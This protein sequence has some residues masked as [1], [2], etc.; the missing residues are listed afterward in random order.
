MADGAPQGPA[1]SWTGRHT[2]AL[3]VL[4]LAIAFMGWLAP[5]F[6]G[7]STGRLAGWILTLV[8]MTVFTMV[9]G[10]GITGL[11]RGVLLDD[12][13]MLSLSRLQLVLWTVVVLSGLLTMALSNVTLG[14]TSPLAIAIPP[15]LWLVMGI[16]TTSLVGSP[17]VLSTKA[18]PDLTPNAGELA[19]TSA[20]LA[21]QGGGT[22]ITTKG[23]VVIKADP[24]SAQWADLFKGEES[25]N[26]AYLDLGKVQ[27]FFFTLVL[28]TVYAVALG[29]QL[30]SSDVALHTFPAL[31]PSL[32]ALL[33]ISHAGYLGNKGI[34]HSQTASNA[35][36]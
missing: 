28:V 23:L 2:L 26:A 27:L 18:N 29:S 35:N 21:R 36:G 31:D 19:K 20:A 16:S 1:N 34:P 11:W 17:L 3:L 12:R 25:G 13:N 32:V 15:Q 6:W 14:Q 30:A 22:G 33:G 9:A 7:P 8:L 4:V 10:Q 24:G 5:L